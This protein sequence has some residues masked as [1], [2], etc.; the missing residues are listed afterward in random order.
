MLHFNCYDI[1]FLTECRL[2]ALIYTDNIIMNNIY[3]FSGFRESLVH[4]YKKEL[5]ET[6][7]IENI[8]LES[9]LWEKLLNGSHVKNTHSYIG[10]VYIPHESNLFFTE[11]MNSIC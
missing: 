9:I 5:H 6:L 7:G 4:V 11:K 1:I 10:F 2:D 8:V 3:F